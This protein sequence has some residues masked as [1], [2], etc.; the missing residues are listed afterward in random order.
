VQHP[1]FPDSITPFFSHDENKA[2]HQPWFCQI[3]V[4]EEAHIMEASRKAR[5]MAE[6]MGFE[7]IAAYHIATAASEL[8]ANMYWHA[9][10]G[11]L[12]ISRNILPHGLLLC[13]DDEG[14]GIPDIEL[15][16]TDGY[17]TGPGLGFGLP[18]V[19]RLMDL[20]EI[21][22]RPGEGCHVRAIKRLSS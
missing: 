15:A 13:A 5:T 6:S 8:A 21:H 19:K 2:P 11:V 14:P 7:R 3:S 4:T 20:F 17:S 16:L 22:S 18:G 10:G 12:R 1:P 9:H